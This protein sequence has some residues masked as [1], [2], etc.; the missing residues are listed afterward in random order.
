M[1]INRRMDKLWQG[2]TMD[3]DSAMWVNKLLLPPTT[4]QNLITHRHPVQK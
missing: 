1:S 3:Y 2:H 4:W